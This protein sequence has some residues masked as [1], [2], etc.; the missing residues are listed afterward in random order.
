MPPQWNTVSLDII[1]P[2]AL[3]QMA[4]KAKKEKQKEKNKKIRKLQCDLL[5]WGTV[6]VVEIWII[7]YKVALN[8]FCHSYPLARST[9]GCES[10][11]KSKNRAPV[12]TPH[13]NKKR[14]RLKTMAIFCGPQSIIPSHSNSYI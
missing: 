13:K 10:D 14:I 6:G 3:F 2:Q 9:F 12:S 5:S 1:R 11:P 7:S 8:H 4:P